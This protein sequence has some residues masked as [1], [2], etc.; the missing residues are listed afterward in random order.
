MADKTFKP[1]INWMAEKYDEYNN[2][3]FS[4]K[5]GKCDF[6]IFTK[7]KGSQGGVLGWFKLCG[8]NVRVSVRSRG[9]YK[10]GLYP[11]E[12][13]KITN[14]NFVEL[15][16]PKIELNGNYSGTENVFIAT[17]VHEMC[18]YY[19]YMNGYC[20]KQCHGP[21]FKQ[22]A[23]EVSLRSN[24]MFSIQRIASA[25]QMNELELSDDMKAKRTN[26]LEKKKTVVSAVVTFLKNGSVKLSLT[27][28]KPLINLIRTSE[29]GCG[30]EVFVTKD[31]DILSYLFNKGYNKNFRTWKYYEIGDK[32]WI[33]E[34]RSMLQN[35]NTEASEE[36]KAKTEQPQN[37]IRRRLFSVR[38]LNGV[39]E[40]DATTYASLVKAIKKRF[41]Q[42]TD[43]S[44]NKLINN[45]MN[46]RMEESKVNI[47]KIVESV[48]NNFI[49]EDIKSDDMIEINQDENLG[50]FS[51]LEI[52][53][54]N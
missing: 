27:S 44:L 48:I 42:I 43:D 5:L 1:D 14:Q 11:Y 8:S 39:F 17:L 23:H 16:K 2:K 25:E 6:G 26:R 52:D 19:T 12:N 34:F 22:I 3:L 28:S 24:G 9:I 15:G 4:G 31:Y 21:E 33:N 37:R 53:G 30:N 32:P 46:Y 41:P 10:C 38:T 13:I 40:C 50:L 49:K 54:N 18:H 36:L 7:G 51:P 47:K 29:E 35:S 20:P 45:P